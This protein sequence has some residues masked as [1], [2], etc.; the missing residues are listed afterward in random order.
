VHRAKRRGE[1]TG[2]PRRWRAG[3]GE[4]MSTACRTTLYAA[5]C[6]LSACATPRWENLLNPGAD[7]QADTM[8]CQR[9]AERAAKMDQ[10]ARPVA[11]Q[12]DCPT[13]HNQSQIRELRVATGAY[14]IQKRC[15]A[16]RGWRQTS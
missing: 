16:A 12:N 10:L 3:K 9:E 13:C 15:M 8:A 4:G 1:T 2:M 5:V 11:F 6:L 14:G 7:F